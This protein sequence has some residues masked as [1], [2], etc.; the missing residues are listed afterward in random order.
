MEA[1]TAT[2][3]QAVLWLR[4]H[5][6]LQ[7]NTFEV[8]KLRGP[9]RWTWGLYS[10]R[11]VDFCSFGTFLGTTLLLTDMYSCLSMTSF[12]IEC[13]RYLKCSCTLTPLCTELRSALQLTR[14]VLVGGENVAAFQ[15]RTVGPPA[16]FPMDHNINE[17][18]PFN[19]FEIRGPETT[20]LISLADKSQ[21]THSLP[22]I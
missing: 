13:R 17:N 1:W 10:N 2:R 20:G 3:G 21:L 12:S 4:C 11:G 16:Q 9:G 7:T 19:L 18:K 6:A 8:P 15:H 5:L 14:V 22:A